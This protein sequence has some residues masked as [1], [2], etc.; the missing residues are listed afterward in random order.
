MQPTNI[1]VGVSEVCKAIYRETQAF[2]DEV[3]PPTAFGFKIL[4]GPPIAKPAILFIGYQPG[5]ADADNKREQL[6]GVHERWPAISEYVSNDW[7]RTPNVAT[8]LQEILSIEFLG[9]CVGMNAIFFRAPSKAAY[10][11]IY[12]SH[13]RARIQTF[14]VS[15]TLKIV[16]TLNPERVVIMGLGT[17]ALFGKSQPDLT[18]A[19][20]RVLTKT[21]KVGDYRS[22]GIMHLT[23]ARIATADRNRIAERLRGG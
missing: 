16:Q 1:D 17:M 4:Y 20:G 14:C 15:K 6:R 12:P 3:S 18:N 11:E 7:P 19:S 9:G 13:F 21:G 23:G 8:R 2:Y 22:L 10:D 5:G